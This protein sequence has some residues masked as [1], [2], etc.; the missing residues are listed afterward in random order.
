MKIWVVAMLVSAGVVLMIT[1]PQGVGQTP[2]APLSGYSA[3]DVVTIVAS[4]GVLVTALGGIIVN[5]IVALRTTHAVKEVAKKVDTVHEATNSN[6]TAV[7]DELKAARVREEHQAKQI[8]DL[9]LL[10]S[11]LKAERDKAAVLTARDKPHPA[12]DGVRKQI[13]NIEELV[14]ADRGQIDNIED[15]VERVDGK[16]PETKKK[17]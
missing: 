11:D 8:A 15:T 3:A 16:I 5:V 4:L 1:A 17:P 10:V 7:K 13:D 14:A 2:T 12:S 6:L 9:V